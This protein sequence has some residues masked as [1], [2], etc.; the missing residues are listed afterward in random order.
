MTGLIDRIMVAVARCFLLL[1]SFDVDFGR[2]CKLFAGRKHFFFSSAYR[3]SVRPIAQVNLVGEMLGKH[4]A[5][6]RI[7]PSFLCLVRRFGFGIGFG[8]VNE[9][10]AP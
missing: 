2:D 9:D 7:R 4:G 1:L 8:V 10:L 3:A 5:D 6:R